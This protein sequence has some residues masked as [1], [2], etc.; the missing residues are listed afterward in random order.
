MRSS[1][2]FNISPYRP[3]FRTSQAHVKGKS[4]KEKS[5]ADYT[6]IKHLC[7]SPDSLTNPPLPSPY[8]MQ[9]ALP[10]NTNNI[11]LTQQ[12]WGPRNTHGPVKARPEKQY[13]N[14][15][16]KRLGHHHIV[17]TVRHIWRWRT[18]Y[19]IWS[20]VSC[21]DSEL[22]ANS[23]LFCQVRSGPRMTSTFFGADPQDHI[24]VSQPGNPCEAQNK[25]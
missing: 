7:A 14:F 15:E 10:L 13:P 24:M 18:A 9:I 21:S 3:Q 20:G 2:G 16:S 1:P 12:C 8:T 17:N 5:S 11:P 4:K 25:V 22:A 19:C 23:F 6:Q